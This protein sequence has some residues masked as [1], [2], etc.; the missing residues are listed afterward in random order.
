MSY[1]EV[2]GAPHMFNEFIDHS[3]SDIQNPFLNPQPVMPP[4]HHVAPPPPGQIPFI[5]GVPPHVATRLTTFQGSGFGE[6]TTFSKVKK[7]VW[8][9]AV[10]GLFIGTKVLMAKN[11]VQ[12]SAMKSQSPAIGEAINEITAV[13]LPVTIALAGGPAFQLLVNR[14]WPILTYLGI[15]GGLG[16]AAFKAGPHILPLLSE[17]KKVGQLSGFK[18]KKRKRKK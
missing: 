6:L 13:H 11:S 2:S 8:I 1:R 12:I 15:L 4:P 5:R 9:A 17:T 18:R 3:K 14:D 16:Y 7:Y 10:T